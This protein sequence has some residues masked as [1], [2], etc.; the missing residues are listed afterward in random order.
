LP[1]NSQSRICAIVKAN[2]AKG[3]SYAASPHVRML[4]HIISK[5]NAAGRQVTVKPDAVRDFSEKSRNLSGLETILRSR[6]QRVLACWKNPAAR[7]G[8][9]ERLVSDY[10]RDPTGRRTFLVVDECLRPEGVAAAIRHEFRLADYFLN[11]DEVFRPKAGNLAKGIAMTNTLQ[12]LRKH[13]HGLSSRHRLSIA[14]SWASKSRSARVFI[15]DEYS[16]TQS[17]NRRVARAPTNRSHR[18]YIS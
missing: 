5:I 16:D 2:L 1:I 11:C 18:R 6:A 13:F 3:N 10:H 4:Q 15:P 8:L 17:C 7:E 9:F 12:Q 14:C